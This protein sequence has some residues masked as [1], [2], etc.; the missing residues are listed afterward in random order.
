MVLK[1]IKLSLGSL[2]VLSFYACK[3]SPKKINSITQIK[4]IDTCRYYRY[5]A[6]QIVSNLSC[7]FCHLSPNLQIKDD[8]GWPTFRGLAA[9]DSLELIN[10]VFTKKHKGWFSKVGPYKAAKMDTLSNCEIK[11]VIRYIKDFGRD[12]PMSSQ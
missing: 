12:I 10:Y 5:D 11:S 7:K 1:T 3:N 8:R 9:I 2:L 6:G 4:S